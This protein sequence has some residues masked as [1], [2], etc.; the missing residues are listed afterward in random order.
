MKIK[1]GDWFK[2]IKDYRM[3]YGDLAFKEGCYY[4]SI[5]DGELVSLVDKEHRMD[6]YGEEERESFIKVNRVSIYG[7][8]PLVATN[9]FMVTSMNLGYTP[10]PEYKWEPKEMELIEADVFGNDN[11][12]QAKFLGISP[13]YKDWPYEVIVWQYGEKVIKRAKSIKQ[14][15]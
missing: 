5:K 7:E 3:D 12:Q 13:K 1:K 6:L 9:P 10:I 14:I 2:C 8:S 4:H 15:K 11:F